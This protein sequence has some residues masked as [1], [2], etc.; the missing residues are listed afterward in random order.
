MC[1]LQKIQIPSMFLPSLGFLITDRWVF[2][3]YDLL[4]AVQKA[5]G[6]R[7]NE[8]LIIPFCVLCLSPASS[9]VSFITLKGLGH[10]LDFKKFD[11]NCQCKP[12]A[13]TRSAGFKIFG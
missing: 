2:V 7:K 4:Y 11:Q 12:K 9:E 10:E 3:Q 8:D 1:F 5:C 6:Y 13:E